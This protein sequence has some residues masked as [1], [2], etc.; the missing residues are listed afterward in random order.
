MNVTDIQQRIMALFEAA[1]SPTPGT[2]DPALGQVVVWYDPQGE[3]A[4]VPAQ[5]DLPGVEVLVEEPDHLFELKRA[6][7]SSLAGRR[8]LLY[9]QRSEGDLRDNWLADVEMLATPFKADYVSMLMADLGA[10]DSPRM[11]AAVQA[12]KKWLGKKTHARRVRELYSAGLTDPRDLYLAVM[13]GRLGKDVQPRADEVLAAYLALAYAAEL[14]ARAGEQAADPLDALAAAG[15]AEQF[16]GLLCT[17]MGQGAHELDGTQLRTRV[18][19]SAL[20]AGMPP[21]A[22]AG[23]ARLE[24]FVLPDKPGQLCREVVRLWKERDPQG[25]T[26]AAREVEAARGVEAVLAVLPMADLADCDALPCVDEVVLRQ[27]LAEAARPS[28]DAAALTSLADRRRALAWDAQYAPY[29]DAASA[30]AQMRR[31]EAQARDG[32]VRETPAQVWQGY[33]DAWWRMDGLYRALHRSVAQAFKAPVSALHDDL[34]AAVFYAE[35]LYKGWYLT[36]LEQAWEQAAGPDLAAQGYATGVA[37]QELFYMNEVAPLAKA[38][39]VFV[40][41][42]D[43]LR[44]E[45]V[46]ELADAL[47]RST[48]GKAEPASMQAVFPSVTKCGMAALL[49]HAGLSLE[50]ASSGGALRVLADGMPTVSC[51]DRQALLQAASEGAVAVR[52]GE[53]MAMGKDE[54]KALVGPARVVYVYHDQIDAVGDSAK[55]ERDVFAACDES[56]EELTGLVRLITGELRCSNVVIT[57]DHG[58]L[59]TYE[60]LAEADKVSTAAV[61]GE[62]LEQG[63]RHVLAAPG[64]ICDVMQQVSMRPFVSD[65]MGFSPRGCLRTAMPGAGQN[66]VHGGISLQELCV[67]VLRFKNLRANAR[68]FEAAR[69]SGLEL[70]TSSSVVTTNRF[71]REFFQKEPVGGKVLAATYEVALVDE[72]GTPVSDTVTLLADKTSE[73]RE[74]RKLRVTLTM[75]PGVAVSSAGTYRLRVRDATT[76][77]TVLTCDQRVDIAFAQEDFGW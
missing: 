48:Q 34:K 74:D 69:P 37:R 63:R 75:R 10:A 41:V 35:G 24:A 25:L 8:V 11:R 5:L 30:L 3:F 28:C 17:C 33:T 21:A 71:A 67:P 55:T 16:K 9:R 39:R 59:Y 57:A 65:L 36:R 12:C 40:V 47:E 70:V 50:T 20:A 14:A 77:E 27:L 58:F 68:D 44:Y 49:P 18:L 73:A 43:A 52:Y 4:D 42:S 38:G 32:F 56:V 62:V 29:Y 64:S 72:A 76:H 1:D 13:A 23:L 51:H 61:V 46:R 45:V 19:L 26:A 7:N 15:V 60:P 31:F 54:R 6:L 53:F 2:P 22:Q 66:F